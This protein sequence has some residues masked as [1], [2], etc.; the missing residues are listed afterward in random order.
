MAQ[1]NINTPIQSNTSLDEKLADLRSRTEQ[2][3]EMERTLVQGETLQKLAHLNTEIRS[4][5]TDDALM[6]KNPNPP[7]YETLAA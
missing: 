4:L 7:Q 6:R 1:E 2:T 5:H 3:K